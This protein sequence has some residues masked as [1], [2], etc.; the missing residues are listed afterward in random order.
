MI[1]G[2]APDR[3]TVSDRVNQLPPFH[4]TVLRL[5]T[6]SMESDSA[7]DDFEDIFKCDPA[8]AADLLV[9][10]NSAAFGLRATIS[11]IRH[12]LALLGLER[13]SSLSFTIAMQFYMRQTPRMASVQ[14][15]WSH[16]LATALIAEILGDIRRTTCRGL[17]TTALMHD[18]GRLGLLMSAGREYADLLSKKFPDI[19][20]SLLYEANRLGT[21]HVEA[22]DVLAEKWCFPPEMRSCIRRHHEEAAAGNSDELMKL[23]RIACGIA[24]RIGY[25]EVNCENAETPDRILKEAAP[26][27][28]AHPKLAPEQLRSHVQKRLVYCHSVR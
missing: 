2:R 25:G 5:L 12:A 4:P 6:V 10:A 9:V 3:S 13:V 20:E 21:T 22:G 1:P 24:T 27:L 23:I 16:A 14:P 15:I 17:Y 7:V 11:S 28:L 8:L 19:G 26:E 18:V